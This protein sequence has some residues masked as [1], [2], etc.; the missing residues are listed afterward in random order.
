[1][2]ADSAVRY[3]TPDTAMKRKVRA[4]LEARIR[5]HAG[6]LCEGVAVDFADYRYRLGQMNGLKEAIEICDVAEKEEGN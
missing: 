2:M 3:F 4:R 5:E 6:F 1:M